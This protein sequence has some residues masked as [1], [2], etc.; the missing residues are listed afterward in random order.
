MARSSFVLAFSF[1]IPWLIAY[2]A[3]RGA[4]R[5]VT[6]AQHGVKHLA[7]RIHLQ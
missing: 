1:T 5:I 4:K 6:G 3:F 7:K 2:S